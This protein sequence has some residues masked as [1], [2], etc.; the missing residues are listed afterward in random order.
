MQIIDG[1]DGHVLWSAEFVC[2][3]L[4]L[5][6]TTVSTSTGHSAFLFW[7]S[8]PIVN[9]TNTTVSFDEGVTKKLDVLVSLCVLHGIC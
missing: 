2:P 7:A 4:D 9:A 1:A 5:E 8:D 6:A 3:S